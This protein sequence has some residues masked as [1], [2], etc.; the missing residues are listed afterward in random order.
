MGRLLLTCS[1]VRPHASIHDSWSAQA[2]TAI[3]P[4]PSCSGNAPESCLNCPRCG[5]DLAR[6]PVVE[7]SV[8]LSRAHSRPRVIRQ[9]IKCGKLVG[10]QRLDGLC[11]RCS[12]PKP[13]VFTR[14][15]HKRRSQPKDPK[16]GRGP[17][18]HGRRTVLCPVCR[19]SVRE[20]RL[21]RHE[22]R[23]HG[24]KKYAGPSCQST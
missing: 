12:K 7:V 5:A 22:K 4:C 9:C 13:P 14:G 11:E 3:R 20:D 10:L 18:K 21:A 1:L 15:T 6:V 16:A 2:M 23:V 8:P 19:V 17:S 24:R